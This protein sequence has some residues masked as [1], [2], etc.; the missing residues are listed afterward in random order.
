[1]LELFDR[2]VIKEKSDKPSC[3]AIWLFFVFIINEYNDLPL[4]SPSCLLGS[5]KHV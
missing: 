2:T 3:I 5:Q 4:I 1:V